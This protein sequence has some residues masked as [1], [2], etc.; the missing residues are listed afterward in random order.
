MEVDVRR[1]NMNQPIPPKCGREKRRKRRGTRKKE[2][3]KGKEEGEEG[4]K[5]EDGEEEE[6]GRQ[7]NDSLIKI[8]LRLSWIL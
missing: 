1:T 6:N 4:R 2:G 5:E 8:L 3:E 7:R